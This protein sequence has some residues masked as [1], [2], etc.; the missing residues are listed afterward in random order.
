[1]RIV[2][3]KRTI[4]TYNINVPPN[5]EHSAKDTELM[6]RS[7]RYRVHEIGSMPLV[8]SQGHRTKTESGRHRAN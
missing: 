1:M 7:R 5:Q 4:Y 3:K 8:R 2:N 6:T